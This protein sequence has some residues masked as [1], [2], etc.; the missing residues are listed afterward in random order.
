MK[1]RWALRL[2]AVLAVPAALALAL[3][4]L[5]VLR[6]PHALATDDARFEAAP[7]LPRKLWNDL[8]VLPGDPATRLL[9]TRDD[10]ASRKTVALYTRINVSKMGDPEQDALRGRVQL[11]VTL[12]ARENAEPMW[13]SRQLN[14]FGVLTLGR[15]STSGPEQQQIL[16]RS[17]GAFQNAIEVDPTNLDAKRNLEILLRRPEAATLPPNDPSQGG[18]QGKVSGQGRSGSGY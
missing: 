11:E 5:D 3:L 9:G 4:A 15:F 10:V 14:L 1:R 7:H 16:A 18:A 6:L 8:G 12:R 17:I 2:V 13:R